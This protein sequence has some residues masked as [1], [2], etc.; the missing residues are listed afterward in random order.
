LDSI[1]STIGRP[2]IV[3][4]GWR[5]DEHNAEVGGVDSSAHTDG[6]GVDIACRESRLRFLI[7]QA[8]LNV[9][10]S[11]IGI[12]KGFVHLDADTSKPPQVAWLY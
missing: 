10:I 9:G 2:L 7:L 12:A 8:A 3:L 4:S 1:R 11:R 5:S 6:L